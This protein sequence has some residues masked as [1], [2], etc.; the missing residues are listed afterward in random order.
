[1]HWILNLFCLFVCDWKYFTILKFEN[2]LQFINIEIS[3]NDKY[4]KNF[5][6]IWNKYIEL[7]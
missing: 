7:L 2:I 5:V 1:M 3:F 6:K 4:C